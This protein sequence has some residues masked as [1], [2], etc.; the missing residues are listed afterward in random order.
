MGEFGFV[1][2]NARPL[3]FQPLRGML[4]FFSVHCHSDRDGDCV[5]KDCP[6]LKDGEPKLTGRH[7]P[8]DSLNMDES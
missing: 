2:R 5:H 4:G 7:C 3:P 1:L 8:L 6:Q